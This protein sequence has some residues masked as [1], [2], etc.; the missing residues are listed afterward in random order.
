MSVLKL[1]SNKQACYFSY[2]FHMDISPHRMMIYQSV[3]AV[4]VPPC[5]LCQTASRKRQVS[6]LCGKQTIHQEVV[7]HSPYTQNQSSIWLNS[8]TICNKFLTNLF[9][10]QT[11]TS[12]TL[13]IPGL[14][15]TTN[16][17]IMPLGRKIYIV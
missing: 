9:N 12:P 8:S 5:F 16:N 1:K 7:H 3:G 6:L 10:R 13:V 15:V 14:R 2:I 11:T 4:W 17:H